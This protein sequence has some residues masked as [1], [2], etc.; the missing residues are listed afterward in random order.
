MLTKNKMLFYEMHLRPRRRKIFN[1]NEQ[2]LIKSDLE[3][4]TYMSLR[5]SNQI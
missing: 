3:V 1:F 5:I 2:L 4:C